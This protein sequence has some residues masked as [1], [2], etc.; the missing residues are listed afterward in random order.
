MP[1]PSINQETA[2]SQF[3]LLFRHLYRKGQTVYAL[4]WQHQGYIFD[5]HGDARPPC[6]GPVPNG[7]YY[8]FVEKEFRYLWFGH[9]WEWTV[10]LYG[11]PL[12]DALRKHPME[13]LSTEIRRNGSS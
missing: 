4:D 8:T 1:F 10:C 9:P 12:L 7:D 6:V 5:P 2:W 3:L 11:K 13:L